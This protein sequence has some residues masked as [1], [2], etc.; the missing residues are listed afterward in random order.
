MLMAC[1]SPSGNENHNHDHGNAKH[2]HSEADNHNEEAHQHDETGKQDGLQLNNGMKWR[3]NDEMRPF[4]LEGEMK[5]ENYIESGDTDYHKLASDLKELNSNLIKNCTMDGPSHDELHK[6]LHPHL[7]LTKALSNAKNP[8]DAR[9]I[10]EKLRHSYHTYNEY[11][12]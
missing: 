12:Q 11:F 2:E 4:V 7:E 1:N 9:E 10:I 8:E 6:W 3:V 5:V